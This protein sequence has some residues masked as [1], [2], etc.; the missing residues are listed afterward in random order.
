[1]KDET[2]QFLHQTKQRLGIAL[3]RIS[4]RAGPSRP[5]S[6]LEKDQ[7]LG[8]GTARDWIRWAVALENIRFKT[9][10][11]NVSARRQGI[12]ESVRFTQIWTGTN[13]L[14]SRDSVL[15]VLGLLPANENELARFRIVYASAGIS[16]SPEEA[17]ILQTL[18]ALLDME[19]DTDDVAPM[20]TL[21]ASPP[22]NPHL[23]APSYPTMWEVIF[24]KYL[25]P[26]DRTRGIGRVIGHELAAHRHPRPDGPVLIYGAR[27]WTVHGMLLTSFFRGSRRKYET[28]IDNINLLLAAALAGASRELAARI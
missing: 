26:T 7:K 27:N 8:L 18:Y 24:S 20:L 15:S 9:K 12:V 16:T 10:G 25:R 11:E 3:D 13:A 19:C 22:R 6:Q 28:F 14:F 17:S 5:L 2:A 1:M 21:P 23:A 4:S